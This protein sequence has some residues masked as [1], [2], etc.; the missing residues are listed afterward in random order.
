MVKSKDFVLQRNLLGLFLFIN[1]LTITIL[2]IKNRYYFKIIIDVFT[3]IGTYIIFFKR[4][5]LRQLLKQHSILKYI[6]IVWGF[7]WL[8]EFSILI[9]KFCITTYF[10]F[11]T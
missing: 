1:S 5:K 3:F 7:F 6:I 2:D 8:F 9:G 11:N 10:F 4:K